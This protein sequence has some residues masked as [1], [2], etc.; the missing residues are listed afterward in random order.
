MGAWLFAGNQ[1]PDYTCTRIISKDVLGANIRLVQ[2]LLGCNP[3]VH[4][5]EANPARRPGGPGQ[6]VGL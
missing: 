1:D 3:A 2:G 6:Q 5:P 4:L